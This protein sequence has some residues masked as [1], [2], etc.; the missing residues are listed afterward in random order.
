MSALIPIVMWGWI[1]FS[2]ILFVFLPARRA[3]LITMIGGWLFLPQSSFVIPLVP[4]YTRFAAVSVP[5]LLGVLLFDARRL[6]PTTDPRRYGLSPLAWPLLSFSIRWFDLPMLAWCLCPIASSLTNGLGLYDG[7]AG[8]MEQVL[9]Y[10]IPY[11]LGR[12]YFSDERGLKELAM[13]LFIGGLIYIPFILYELRMSPQLHRYLYGSH[14]T[15]FHKAYRW[16]GYRPWVFMSHGIEL[17]LWMAFA[18]MSGLW[19]WRTG[20]LRRLWGIGTGWWNAALFVVFVMC[21][22]ANGWGIAL[23]GLGSLFMTRWCRVKFFLIIL[24][25]MPPVYITART[26]VGYKANML[27]GFLDQVNP[28]RADSLR[29]RI[30]HEQV[31]MDRAHQRPVFGWGTY[32]RNRAQGDLPE[33][34]MGGRS[35]TDSMWIITYGQKGMFGLISYGAVLLLPPALLLRR[36]RPEEWARPQHACAAVMAVVLVGYAIDGLYTMKPNPVYIVI[37]GGVVAYAVALRRRQPAPA[38]QVVGEER[39][40]WAARGAEAGPSFAE[41]DTRH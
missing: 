7:L 30:A 11:M 41:L 34:A 23:L 21:K 15:E 27:I 36:L 24:L 22:A 38:R 13:A 25:L 3:V 8:A 19:M 12:I 17:G 20:A 37:A 6:A 29:S 35:T 31:L 32:G 16:G 2:L 1:P 40:A 10:G 39:P 14:P 4:D 18:S 28:G 9:N 33:A 26:M 5:A